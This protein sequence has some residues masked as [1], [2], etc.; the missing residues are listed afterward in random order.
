M[1]TTSDNLSIQ[2]HGEGIQNKLFHHLS[3]DGGEAD[4]PAVSWILFLALF[5][6]TGYPPV[7]WHLSH[8]QDLSEM[9]E[10]GS[11]V[12]SA[13]SLSAHACIPLG[14]MDL[15]G[16]DFVDFGLTV[17][18][19]EVHL[20]LCIISY[21]R[22]AWVEKVHNDHRLSTPLLCAGLPTTE[23]GCPEPHPAWP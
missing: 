15:C 17:R 9:I 12:T 13:S 7:L 19:I 14:A 23:P 20:F 1:L 6:D 2:L 3:R 10:S 22:M 18:P 4:W 16:I 8:R 21:H 5:E 11:P